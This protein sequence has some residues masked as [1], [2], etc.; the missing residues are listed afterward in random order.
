MAGEDDKESIMLTK[1]ERLVDM[2]KIVESMGKHIQRLIGIVEAATRGLRRNPKRNLQVRYF[3]E[4]KAMMIIV[5]KKG[6][7]MIY[8]KS[9]SVKDFGFK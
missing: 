8:F 9:Y 5:K 4:I 2:E 7:R 6:G 3:R 1:V